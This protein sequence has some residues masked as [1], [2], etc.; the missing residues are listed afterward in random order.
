MATFFDLGP[1]DRKTGNARRDPNTAAAAAAIESAASRDAD[2]DPSPFAQRLIREAE[3]G[4]FGQAGPQFALGDGGVWI[5]FAVGELFPDAARI[6]GPAHVPELVSDAAKPVRGPGDTAKALAKR[7]RG[8][9]GDGRLRPAIDELK[10]H[11]P[12][13]EAAKEAACCFESSRSRMDC[14][15]LPRRRPSGRLGPGRV[16]LPEPCLRA[17]QEVRDVPEFRG[18]QQDPRPTQ[19]RRIQRLRRLSRI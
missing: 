6:F 18:R 8:M 11:A 4:G 14:P 12:R 7:R 3:R 19:C 9:T 1:P 13:H 10:P 15:A 17:A 2:K 5:R 16:D